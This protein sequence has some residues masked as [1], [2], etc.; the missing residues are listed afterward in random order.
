[1]ETKKERTVKRYDIRRPYPKIYRQRYYSERE[2]EKEREKESR[3]E[4]L[5]RSPLMLLLR[6]SFQRVIPTY[7]LPLTYLHL[8]YPLGHRAT[9]L[10]RRK[11]KERR[12]HW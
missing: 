1:M 9:F 6:L 8:G 7:H 4:Y 12:R 2:R 5:P 11:E 3:R 10:V